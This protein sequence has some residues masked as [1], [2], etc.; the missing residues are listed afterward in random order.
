MRPRPGA[1]LAGEGERCLA[2]CV[3]LE[4]GLLEAEDLL[5]GPD[6]LR[7]RTDLTVPALLLEPAQSVRQRHQ[8]YDALRSGD[9]GLLAGEGRLLASEDALRP[10]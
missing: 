6:V 9:S 10:E 7:C 8:A 5:S 3:P 1:G 2:L 4:H